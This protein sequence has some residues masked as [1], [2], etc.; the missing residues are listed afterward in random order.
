MDLF[1]TPVLIADNLRRLM[2]RD[3]LTVEMLIDRTRLNRR[4][5]KSLLQGRATRPHAKTLN[6][7]ATGLDVCVDELFQ[8]PSTLAQRQFDRQTN[9]AVD[10]LA[11][12][13][14]Q[15]FAGWTRED[16]DELYSRVGTGG[17]LTIT[18][19]RQVTEAMNH[20]RQLQAK[21]S[22]LLESSE[23]DLLESLVEAL[24]RRV[25]VDDDT[26]TMTDEDAPIPSSTFSTTIGSS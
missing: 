7:L 19:A 17:A 6:R 18:G 20:K 2:A 24:Y 1:C 25:L 12:R 22:L 11:A 9:P 21:I 13:Q 26:Q 8:N 16:F 4:T 15:L 5:I 14:P 23:A 10:E 3:G